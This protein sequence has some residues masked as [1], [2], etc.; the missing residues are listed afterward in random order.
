[1]RRAIGVVL[2]LALFTLAGCSGLPMSWEKPRI[3]LAGFTLKDATFFQQ[4]FVLALTVQNPNNIS[5]AVSGLDARLSVNGIEMAQGVSNEQ[6]TIPALGEVTLHI[7]VVSNIAQL[8][9]QL[10]AL[11]SDEAPTY[12][13][14]GRIYLPVKPDGIAFS[15]SGDM[16]PRD[17]WLP[18]N[19]RF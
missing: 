1:M 2:A 10:R 14:T 4:R 18:K 5:V 7:E 8:V 19:L 11:K 15:K 17:D 12:K 16:P 9:K 13:L 3:S 6:M